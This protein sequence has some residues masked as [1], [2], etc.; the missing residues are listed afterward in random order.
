M[1]IKIGSR[2]YMV[3]FES[4]FDS[5]D[6]DGSINY[7]KSTIHISKHL[8]SDYVKETLL[9]EVLHGIS[10]DAK[11]YEFFDESVIEKFITVFTP[12]LLQ[13]FRDNKDFREM[14]E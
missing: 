7:T 11:L 2:E 1:R 12:R 6:I 3:D 10:D 4:A 5:E 9:H 8:S 14:L 13:T